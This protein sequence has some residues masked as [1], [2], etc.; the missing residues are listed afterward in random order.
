MTLNAQQ[1]HNLSPQF[2]NC[3]LCCATRK[4]KRQEFAKMRILCGTFLPQF[5]T[6][7]HCT[8]KVVSYMLFP[9]ICFWK[10]PE[11]AVGAGRRP[12]RGAHTSSDRLRGSLRSGDTGDRAL[13]KS[14]GMANVGYD[15]LNRKR[16][17]I[18]A[19]S[20]LV[21]RG[22]TRTAR[23]HDA[24]ATSGRAA[25]EPSRKCKARSRT[26]PPAGRIAF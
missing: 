20:R 17:D 3:G 13:P 2:A 9:I 12:Y 1:N 10:Q 15:G 22:G 18:M 26:A 8:K 6:E 24:R 21:R 16:F 25:S 19:R 11:Q 5:K 4:V 14:G 7:A 23:N